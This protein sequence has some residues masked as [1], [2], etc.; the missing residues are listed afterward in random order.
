MEYVSHDIK[1][2]IYIDPQADGWEHGD[3]VKERDGGIES[4]AQKT[5]CPNSS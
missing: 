2:K 4:D 3:S 1:Y 5:N